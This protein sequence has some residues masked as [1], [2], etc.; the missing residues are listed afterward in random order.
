MTFNLSP[1][2]GIK[3]ALL[4][5]VLLVIVHETGRGGYDSSSNLR[6]TY[7][8]IVVGSGSAGSVVAARLT[9]L[10][11]QVLLLEAGGEPPVESHIPALHP[12]LYHEGA[13]ADWGYRLQTQEGMFGAWKDRR[14]PYARGHV[15]GGSSTINYMAY[16]RGNRRDFDNWA[17]MGNPGWDYNTTLQYF[18]KMED[19]KGAYANNGYH[20]YNG[21]LS[22]ESKRWSTPLL[23]GFLGAGRELG[24]NIIDYN[25]KDQIG[26][27][28]WELTVKNG[29]RWSTAEAYLK[30][31]NK[32]SNL[33]VALNALVTKIEFD[34][35][36]RAIG[37]RYIH[38][39]QHKIALV[40][41]EVILSAGAIN[42]PQVLL[43]SG[44]GPKKHLQQHGIPMVVDLPGVGQNLQDHPT[45][46]TLTWL[47][48]RPGS[49]TNSLTFAHP[50]AYSEYTH[51][52][53][54]PLSVPMGFEASGW[55]VGE[56]DP[57]WP[58]IQLNFGSATAGIDKGLWLKEIAGFDNMFYLSYFGG[59]LGLDG[60]GILPMLTRAKSRGSITLKSRDPREAPIIDLN[61]L[62]HP[63][64]MRMM[65]KAI[66]WALKVGGM[67]SLKDGFGARFHDKALPGCEHLPLGSDDYWVCYASQTVYTNYHP[68]GSCKMG[69][70]TDPY[71]VVD[72]RLKVRGV[73][74][75]RVID[76][77]IMPLI[78]TGNTNAPTIMIGE[79][80]SDLIKEDWG[81]P[82][83]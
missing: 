70:I 62:S 15:A 45:V 46:T 6:T 78:T 12:L 71:S 11:W 79:R 17:A 66:K 8:F 25:G 1:F 37:V 49:G 75:L 16:V 27:S 67:S 41:C 63:Y 26:F 34:K 59:I 50:I 22:V 24:Y 54:G 21:P 36:K 55:L 4:R 28:P 20:G 52:R 80:A 14:P 57:S 29:Q 39:R 38:N 18:K 19:Y 13:K 65:V 40:R 83:L 31:A 3:V 7:D 47:T 23:K 9:E 69:P 32:R 10:G 73:S 44:V 51:S 72:H 43:L 77:S 35:N 48:N 76:A 2:L 74:G 64:D 58:D 5:L 68:V 60:F 61:Y 30:P 56:T 82:S 33:H 53:T 42:S 81:A